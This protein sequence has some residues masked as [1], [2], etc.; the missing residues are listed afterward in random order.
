MCPVSSAVQVDLI[1]ILPREYSTNIKV[2]SS[3]EL[4]HYWSYI[5]HQRKDSVDVE[6]SETSVPYNPHLSRPSS[7][8]EHEALTAPL[9]AGP[10]DTPPEL[11]LREPGAKRESFGRRLFRAMSFRAEEPPPDIYNTAFSRQVNSA[12]YWSMAIMTAYVVLRVNYYFQTIYE[13]LLWTAQHQYPG[14]VLQAR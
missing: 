7:S 14:D 5:A 6:A 8:T 11:P 10:S 12:V 2:L 13:Q 3:G 1:R 9:L 4:L